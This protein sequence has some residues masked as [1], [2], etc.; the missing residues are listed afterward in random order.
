MS[1]VRIEQKS[2]ILVAISCHHCGKKLASSVPICSGQAPY[3]DRAFDD[4]PEIEVLEVFA[5]TSTLAS[6]SE[7]VRQPGLYRLSRPVPANA[8]YPVCR[9]DATS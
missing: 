8:G 7:T 9:S 4:S 3:L 1:S 6:L 5:R 2:Y